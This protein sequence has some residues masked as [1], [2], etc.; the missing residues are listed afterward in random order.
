MCNFSENT[1]KNLKEAGWFPGRNVSTDE[2]EKFIADI[3]IDPDDIIHINLNDTVRRFLQEFGKLR[4][5]IPHLTPIVSNDNTYISYN[6][7]TIEVS[8]GLLDN[9]L[10]NESGWLEDY[11]R[12][13]NGEKLV[14]IGRHD[15]AVYFMSYSGKIYVGIKS[16][17]IQIAGDDYYAALEN[18]CNFYSGLEY[19]EDIVLHE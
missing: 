13:L 15:I 9:K 10:I 3:E 6:K 17:F 2:F 7:Y 8:F 14:P 19:Q 16:R 1:I 12:I 5:F 4:L 18:I 11:E